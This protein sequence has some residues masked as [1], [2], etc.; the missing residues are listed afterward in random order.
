MERAGSGPDL[1]RHPEPQ[2]PGQAVGQGQGQL[3]EAPR[4]RLQPARQVT[5]SWSSP[6]PDLPPPGW[7]PRRSST[8]GRV[9]S[10]KSSSE[11]WTDIRHRDTFQR[12]DEGVILP[13]YPVLSALCVILFP[14]C[15]YSCT[16]HT[17]HECMYS[18]T[19]HTNHERPQP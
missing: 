13:G 16:C 4:C 1:P 14:A 19:C 8:S 11:I 7:P 10:K 15:I 2:L 6:S 12:K 3:E 17:N 9:A 18:C 5:W